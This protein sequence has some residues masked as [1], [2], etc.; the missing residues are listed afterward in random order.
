[1]KTDHT[2]NRSQGAVAV[3]RRSIP[4]ITALVLFMGF[5]AWYCSP[6][7]EG[8]VLYAGDTMSWRG[9][10]HEAQEY[11]QQTGESTWW[12]NSMFGGM[13]TYQI[14]GKLPS[15]DVRASI[16][17]IA[18]GGMTGNRQAIGLLFAYLLGFFL[19]LRCFRVNPW[20]SIAGAFAIGLSTYFLL[21]IPAGHITKALAIGYLAP[22]TG[23]VYAVFRKRYWYGVPLVMVYGLLGLTA[24]PQ[25]KIG[26]AHV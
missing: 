22:M 3:L 8:K 24:H 23:G 20:L 15:N 7:L 2:T 6:L 5:A 19:M 1:M 18:H 21:I 4:Y 10:A 25:M 11:Y 16:E 9:A 13:P 26:R 12:T 17:H 14:T